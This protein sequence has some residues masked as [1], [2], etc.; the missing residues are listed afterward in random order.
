MDRTRRM[1]W[2]GGLVAAAVAAAPFAFLWVQMVRAA[3][4]PLSVRARLELAI[5]MAV[6]ATPWI[7]AAWLL[8]RAWW[9]Q[10]GPQLA[11]LDGPAGCW[12]RPRPPSP[13]AD[14]PGA[15]P[16]PPS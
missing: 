15:R 5:W 6:F 14:A 11:T 13:P 10:T 4:E 8:W 2:A 3:D 9:R 7:I 1:G 16:W 12:P